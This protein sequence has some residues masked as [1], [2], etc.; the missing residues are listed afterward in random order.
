[1]F[2]PLDKHFRNPNYFQARNIHSIW[3]PLTLCYPSYTTQ[4]NMHLIFLTQ[5]AAAQASTEDTSYA[6]VTNPFLPSLA[7]TANGLVALT[8]VNGYF[9]S[10]IWD[11]NLRGYQKID[12]RFGLMLQFDYTRSN[13]WITA[14]HFGGRFG[15][16]FSLQK[17]GL[18]GWACT[19]FF[20]GGGTTIKAGQYRLSRWGNIGIGGEIG[21]TTIY[22][23][24]VL[25]LAIGAYSN[26]N[27]GYTSYAQALDQS[28]SPT[29]F[30]IKPIVHIG[31]GYAF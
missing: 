31:L 15:P 7:L 25:D 13:I 19:P 14:T 1:M 21:H 24:M 26:K 4:N 30:P 16:R 18:S 23:Q 10:S 12:D 28:T 6:I 22:K 3:P 20:I 17:Q 9:N 11:A 29:G 5:F 27:I 8:G 2:V